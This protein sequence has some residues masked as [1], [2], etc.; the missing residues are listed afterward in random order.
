M[1]TAMVER[2]ASCSV[3][4]YTPSGK[5]TTV[6]FAIEELARLRFSIVLIARWEE[7]ERGDAERRME[8]HTELARL[9]THYF[10]K[11]D[12][13]AMTFGVQQAMDAKEM[14][15]H[16]V[17]VPRGAALPGSPDDE[18]TPIF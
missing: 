9:R 11:I 17:F 3:N 15:E 2:T 7:A 14:V 5:D 13:M 10:E 1:S 16:Q 6:D 12:E 4:S 8:L 18:G